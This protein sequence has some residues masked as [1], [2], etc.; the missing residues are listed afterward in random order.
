MFP[1]LEFDYIYADEDFPY[2][3][4]EGHGVDGSI[5]FNF[6]EDG[7]DEA[8]SLYIEC[9]QQEWDNF[10]KTEHGWDWVD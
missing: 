7:S 5:S 10:K 2:N 3:C 4:G 9:W 8:M 6:P 1:N